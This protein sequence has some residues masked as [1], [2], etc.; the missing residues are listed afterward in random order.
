MAI[1]IKRKLTVETLRHLLDYNQDTGVF[2]W[3]YNMRTKAIGD[4]AGRNV[5]G[6]RKISINRE[7]IYAHRLAWLFVYG[8]WPQG[9]IDHINR[10]RDDNRIENLRTATKSQNRHYAGLGKSNRSGFRG[11]HFSKTDKYGKERW[12]AQIKINGH[13]IHIGYFDIPEAAHEAYQAAAKHYFGDF[14]YLPD[15][16]LPSPE[17][18]VSPLPMQCPAGL[19]EALL[20]GANP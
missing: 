15:N 16:A 19:S 14:A 9:E 18:R 12:R 8:E 13:R 5:R 6:Y 20:Y 11:V 7:S 3:R 10:K 4:V 1:D 17:Q 2:R